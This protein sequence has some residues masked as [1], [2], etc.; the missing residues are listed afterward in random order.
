MADYIGI[1]L[2]LKVVGGNS[3]NLDG[4]YVPYDSVNHAISEIPISI[5][6][7]GLTV[8]I[9]FLEGTVE[10]VK[11]Y[12]WKKG[13]EDTNLELKIDKAASTKTSELLN[14]AD[15]QSGTQVEESL[16]TQLNIMNLYNIQDFSASGTITS[17]NKNTCGRINSLSASAEITFP[18]ANQCTNGIKIILNKIGSD[19]NTVTIIADVNIESNILE[20]KGDF[21]VYMLK[22][23]ALGLGIHK[24]YNILTNV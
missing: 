3:A 4:K 13:I 1:S 6:R 22:K 15:F 19:I 18:N 20:T 24:W 10:T 2:P 11:E 8:G 16:Q 9:I 23:D 5:R 12:W 17:I 7:V 21:S 14:D